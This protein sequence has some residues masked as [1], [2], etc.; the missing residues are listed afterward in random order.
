MCYKSNKRYIRL[1]TLT[2]SVV[3]GSGGGSRTARS[4]SGRVYRLREYFEEDLLRA[5]EDIHKLILRGPTL[6]V[7]YTGKSVH[8]G[9]LPGQ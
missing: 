4:S 7:K 9:K 3:V 8:P 2:E 5:L 1:G 6:V